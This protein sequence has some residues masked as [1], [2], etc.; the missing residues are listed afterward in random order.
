[1]SRRRGHVGGLGC[2]SMVGCGEDLVPGQ[3]GTEMLGLA[4][5][6]GEW[7]SG[8]GDRRDRRAF[9]TLEP[10]PAPPCQRNWILNF[11]FLP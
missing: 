3:R 9:G 6:A 1:M 10:H 4:E 11:E 7:E 5:E 8:R 2:K